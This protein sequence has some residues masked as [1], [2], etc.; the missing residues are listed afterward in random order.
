ML[1]MAEKKK[2]KNQIN[3]KCRMRGGG[4]QKSCWKWKYAWFKKNIYVFV[5]FCGQALNP[6]H[7]D[8]GKAC[9]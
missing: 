3:V 7:Q 5:Y 4:W 6:D 8:K 9:L 1:T 2:K